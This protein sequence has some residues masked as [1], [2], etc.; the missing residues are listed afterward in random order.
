M[1]ELMN[2]LLS[3]YYSVLLLCHK[4]KKC[5]RNNKLYLA[6]VFAGGNLTYFYKYIY[7]C[8]SMQ[9]QVIINT[10]LLSRDLRLFVVLWPYSNNNITTV[11]GSYE[12]F[13]SVDVFCL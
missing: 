12:N 7:K 6:F 9:Q 3:F 1:L 10:G 13:L 11:T 5:S 8:V 2:N 4:I